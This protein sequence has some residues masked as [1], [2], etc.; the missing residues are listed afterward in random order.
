LNL[1]SFLFHLKKI[2]CID[3]KEGL[4]FE[5]EPDAPLPQALV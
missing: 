2:S 5:S 1:C 3:L 4:I